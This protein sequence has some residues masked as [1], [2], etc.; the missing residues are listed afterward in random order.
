MLWIH[1]NSQSPDWNESIF[2]K[3]VGVPNECGKR[4]PEGK[5]DSAVV[6]AA[7]HAQVLTVM[8]SMHI[9]WKMTN[10]IIYGHRRV[11][12]TTMQWAPHIPACKYLTEGSAPYF[13]FWI[14]YFALRA[15]N[16]PFILSK[17]LI[18]EHF[19][20]SKLRWAWG[21]SILGELFN[22]YGSHISLRKLQNWP[23]A[24]WASCKAG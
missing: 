20:P 17:S 11:A 15:R 21:Y 9:Q 2:L 16:Q 8:C 14:N 6:F 4:F 10:I 7:A 22:A 12:V 3:G 23:I 13:T 1:R 19:V 18:S 5:G 24:F